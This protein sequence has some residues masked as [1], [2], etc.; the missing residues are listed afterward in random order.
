MT[1]LSS[2][3]YSECLRELYAGEAPCGRA[4]L[5]PASALDDSAARFVGVTKLAGPLL[6]VKLIVSVSEGV[7]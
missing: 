1:T 2:I 3:P 6:G 4:R 5:G 7:T